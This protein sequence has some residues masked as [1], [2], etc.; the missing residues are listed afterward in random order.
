MGVSQTQ[1]A[2]FIDKICFA[3]YFLLPIWPA[4]RVKKY[5]G[6]AI[7]VLYLWLLK[8]EGITIAYQLSGYYGL[9]IVGGLWWYL[10]LIVTLIYYAIVCYALS[11]V[12]VKGNVAVVDRLYII[13]CCA[14]L[15]SI[16]ILDIYSYKR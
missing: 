1:I 9:K 13:L 2:Q 5:W 3:L 15:V 7:V 11:G 14:I 4:L 8:G 16:V 6:H 10:G 12:R